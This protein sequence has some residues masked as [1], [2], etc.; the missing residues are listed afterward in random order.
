MEWTIPGIIPNKVKNILSI[1]APIL[2]VDNTARGGRTMQ[3]KY[4]MA[5][6]M[7]NCYN[8]DGTNPHLLR[9]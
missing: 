4:L 7:L 3:K 8:L 9:I 5:I 1:K 6:C 2:P